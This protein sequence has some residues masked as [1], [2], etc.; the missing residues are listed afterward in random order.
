MRLLKPGRMRLERSRFGDVTAPADETKNRRKTRSSF[1]VATRDA[2]EAEAPA[3]ESLQFRG[4][5]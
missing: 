1:V 2:I 3:F 5:L 4:A